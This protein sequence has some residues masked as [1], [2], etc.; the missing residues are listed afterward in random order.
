M[1]H[2]DITQPHIHIWNVLVVIC[3]ELQTWKQDSPLT[4]A[5]QHPLVTRF[6]WNFSA[7]SN[8][9]MGEVS[10]IIIGKNEVAQSYCSILSN[11]NMLLEDFPDW[12]KHYLQ[13]HC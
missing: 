12:Q 10:K 3:K 1:I 2:D 5:C 4:Q 8:G 7:I 6:D 9:L 11:G 13:I